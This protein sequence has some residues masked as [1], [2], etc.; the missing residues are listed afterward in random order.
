MA[1]RIERI[2]YGDDIEFTLD[3][4]CQYRC[5][6]T[7]WRFDGET[8]WHGTTTTW[9]P[10]SDIYSAID[11]ALDEEPRHVGRAEPGRLM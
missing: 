9:L 2:E 7:T 5:P 8:G 6:Q 1:K 3:G 11:A 4:V 10:C